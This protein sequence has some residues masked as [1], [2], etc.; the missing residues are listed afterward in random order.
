MQSAAGIKS[1]LMQVVQE[2][3]LK[4]SRLI[5]SLRAPVHAGLVVAFSGGVDSACLLF[6]AVHTAKNHGGRVIA[7]TTASESTPERDLKDAREFAAKLGVEHCIVKSAEL[8]DERYVKNDE[9]RCLYC[10]TELFTI[11]T[12]VAAEQACAFIAYGYTASDR[13][14]HRPGHWAAQSAGVISPLEEAGLHKDEIRGILRAHGIEIAE[15]PAAPCLASRIRT[16]LPVTPKRLSDVQK[17]EETLYAG[18][19]RGHRV[20][21]HDDSLVRIE[22]DPGQMEK[23]LTLREEVARL[24]RELG[25]RWTVLDLLGYRTGGAGA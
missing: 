15:K 24:A 9:N 10:K 16:G 8:E 6:A 5:D 19:M 17:I 21:I 1:V 11:A 4:W 14:E 3:D 13:G 7:L 20:R 23:L 2:S 18:G 25:Y 22:C 12:R